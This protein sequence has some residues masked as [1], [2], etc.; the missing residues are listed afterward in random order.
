MGIVKLIIIHD[1]SHQ[2]FSHLQELKPGFHM[3]VGDCSRSLGSLVN[4]SVIVMIIWKPKFSFCQRSPMILVTANDRNDH[5]PGIESESISVIV[6][7]V[8]DRQ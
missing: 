2:C 6:A 7:I 3:I 8:N 4:C 5:D 1:N